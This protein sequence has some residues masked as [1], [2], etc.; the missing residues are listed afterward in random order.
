MGF[1][2]QNVYFRDCLDSD[3]LTHSESHAMPPFTHLIGH[4]NWA[5]PRNFGLAIKNSKDRGV[6]AQ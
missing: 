3:T 6:E 2:I 5:C 1:H 4:K